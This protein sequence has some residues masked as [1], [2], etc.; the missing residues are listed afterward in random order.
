MECGWGVE[1]S[2]VGGRGA[3]AESAS[4]MV[5]TWVGNMSEMRSATARNMGWNGKEKEDGLLRA[6]RRAKMR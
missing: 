2:H 4:A 3:V 1:F 5:H 6:L